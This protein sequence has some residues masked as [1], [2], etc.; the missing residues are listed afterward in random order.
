MMNAKAILYKRSLVEGARKVTN[1]KTIEVILG[2]MF[3]VTKYWK[4]Q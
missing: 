1:E 2:L 3:P 4:F